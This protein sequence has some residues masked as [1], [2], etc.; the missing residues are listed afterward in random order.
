MTTVRIFL[1]NILALVLIWTMVLS[2]YALASQA[3]ATNSRAD[4]KITIAIGAPSKGAHT[5][6]SMEDHSSNQH[7]KPSHNK[8]QDC[9]D[10]CVKAVSVFDVRKVVSTIY[11]PEHKVFSLA[12]FDNSDVSLAGEN[13]YGAYN[14]QA[15]PNV[16]SKQGVERL[17]L[18]NARLR[19]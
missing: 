18:L 7:H 13:W 10:A 12:W 15:P 17:L 4:V 14:A 8:R 1:A 19:N 2:S 6:K 3:L 5:H 16:A 11:P 9:F